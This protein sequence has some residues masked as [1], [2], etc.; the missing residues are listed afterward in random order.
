MS[1]WWGLVRFVRGWQGRELAGAAYRSQVV[2]A[3]SGIGCC[4]LSHSPGSAPLPAL[5]LCLPGF[6]WVPPGL[7]TLPPCAALPLAALCPACRI[8]P[9]DIGQAGRIGGVNPTD[10][11]NLLVFLETRRR[12]AAARGDA[13]AAADQ[14]PRQPTK[15]E[16]RK[17]LMAEAEA[18][19]TAA[20]GGASGGEVTEAAVGEQAPLPV[21]V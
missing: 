13:E 12:G 15:K 8:R 20:S 2:A 18:A 3:R 19:A 9:R 11:S 17:Q 6:R 7:L 4:M 21:A 10:I 14:A 1:G 5:R 16:H